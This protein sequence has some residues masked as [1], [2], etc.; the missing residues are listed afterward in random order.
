VIAVK[1]GAEGLPVAVSN[2]ARQLAII[3]ILLSV[4]GQSEKQQDDV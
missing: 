4:N 1:E 3:Q 2:S